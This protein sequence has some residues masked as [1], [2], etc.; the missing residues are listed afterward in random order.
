MLLQAGSIIGATKALGG[1]GSALR[2][3]G[4]FALRTL[5]P[6]LALE[7]FLV[8]LAGGESVTGELVDEIFGEG[9]EAK[10]QEFVAKTTKAFGELFSVFDPI[11]NKKIWQTIF[12]DNALADWAAFWTELL[13]APG[14][15]KNKLSN[16]FKHL[17][18][19][20]E[21][22]SKTAG[23]HVEPSALDKIPGLT[24]FRN[25][26]GP[27]AQIDA[28]FRKSKG[29]APA[30]G[31]GAATIG[32]EPEPHAILDTLFGGLRDKFGPGKEIDRKARAAGAIP[33][34]GPASSDFLP[35]LSEKK[36][37]IPVAGSAAPTVN[38]TNNVENHTNVTATEPT[39]IAKKVEKAATK[40]TQKGIDMSAAHAALVPAAG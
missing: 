30:R 40:G 8:F 31:Q 1:F 3:V 24:Q 9:S 28:E 27:G 29:L 35:N 19:G 17:L 13:V 25:A 15:F 12:G 33:A 10:A 16:A 34:L 32:E 6:L 7:D 22:L 37:T 38:V 39:D 18:S 26:F 14:D 36:V 11:K 4:G 23:Q 20:G 21:D 2:I 5:A